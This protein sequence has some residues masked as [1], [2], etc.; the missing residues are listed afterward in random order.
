MSETT[1]MYPLEESIWIFK[2]V[3]SLQQISPLKHSF[4]ENLNSVAGCNETALCPADLLIEDRFKQM[5]TPR[6]L[7]TCPLSTSSPTPQNQDQKLHNSK[8]TSHAI[9]QQ[10]ETATMQIP[11]RHRALGTLN[12]LPGGA[13][14]LLM[15]ARRPRCDHH[16]EKL[17]QHIEQHNMSSLDVELSRTLFENQVKY[18]L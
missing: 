15:L 18:T 13:C 5:A 11:S 6:Q 10:S 9:R 8:S 1:I 17:S 12:C 3:D 14:I 7:R 2:S 4:S 16:P